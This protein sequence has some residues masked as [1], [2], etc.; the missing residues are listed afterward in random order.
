MWAPRSAAAR[1]DANG[2]GPVDDAGAQP[3]AAFIGILDIFGFEVFE[4]NSYEQ[5]L[6]K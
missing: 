1:P 3:V 6:I 2:D 5:L 4:H